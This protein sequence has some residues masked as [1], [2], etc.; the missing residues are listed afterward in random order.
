MTSDL[1]SHLLT[2]VPKRARTDISKMKDQSETIGALSS[3]QKDVAHLKAVLLA[4]TREATSSRPFTTSRRASDGEGRAATVAQSV[5]GSSRPRANASPAT[6]PTSPNKDEGEIGWDV[7]VHQSGGGR[8]LKK[9]QLKGP[10]ELGVGDLAVPGLG[11]GAE[12]PARY[13]ARIFRSWAEE[14]AGEAQ[15]AEEPERTSERVFFS[16][17]P[18]PGTDVPHQPYAN[19]G[20]TNGSHAI[21]EETKGNAIYRSTSGARAHTPSR[22]PSFLP[23]ASPASRPPEATSLEVLARKGGSRMHDR[24]GHSNEQSNDEDR[25]YMQYHSTKVQGQRPRGSQATVRSQATIRF[26]PPTGA[27][28]H[29]STPTGAGSW[30]LGFQGLLPL[31]DPRAESRA[32]VA[33]ARPDDELAYYVNKG[34][35]PAVGARLWEVQEGMKS[36]H[37][38]ARGP[39]AVIKSVPLK[40]TSQTPQGSEKSQLNASAREDTQQALRAESGHAQGASLAPRRQPEVIF[41]E[42]APSVGQE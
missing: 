21:L 23:T 25:A 1:K 13:H 11:Q 26:S 4:N 2:T 32:I 18:L 39:S 36:R 35:R 42:S 40:V 8:S 14:G 7:S 41:F 6:S 12:E 24:R 20:V 34:A 29:L 27:P 5:V 3:L 30:G 15:V 19:H 33:S 38:R 10:E 28:E 22:A 9:E 17:G 37:V 31:R 16:S